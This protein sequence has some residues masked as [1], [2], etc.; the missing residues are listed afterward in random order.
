MEYPKNIYMSPRIAIQRFSQIMQRCH[1]EAVHIGN[2]YREEKEALIAAQVVYGIEQKSG[3]QHYLQNGEHIAKDIDIKIVERIP[4][5]DY[6]RDYAS[7]QITEFESN[8]ENFIDVFKNKQ[9]KG[10]KAGELVLVIS[11][12]DKEGWTFQAEDL[13]RE[14]KEVS[15]IYKT[16]WLVL[17]DKNEQ[18]NYYL[19]ELYP[20]FEQIKF[21]IQDSFDNAEPPDFVRQL[22]KYGKHVEAEKEYVLALPSCPVCGAV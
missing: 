14:I 7:L 11:V 1:P 21:N 18:W 17:E 6:L 20:N 22:P 9:K 15:S 13:S 4:E 3:G 16:V 19:I 10:Y 8:N 5:G 2:N 12:R